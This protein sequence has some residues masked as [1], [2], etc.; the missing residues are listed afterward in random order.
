MFPDPSEFFIEEKN[1]KEMQCFIKG[2][3]VLPSRVEYSVH[4]TTMKASAFFVLKRDI[5]NGFYTHL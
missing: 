5:Q 1:I 4:L 2:S 3:N